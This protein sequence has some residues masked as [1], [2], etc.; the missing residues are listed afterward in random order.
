MLKKVTSLFMILIML[1]SIP[2]MAFASNLEATPGIKPASLEQIQNDT[3]QEI[4]IPIIIEGEEPQ[5]ASLGTAINFYLSRQSPSSQT[6]TIY[7][8]WTGTDLISGFRVKSV[9]VHKG[10]LLNDETYATIAPSGEDLFVYT[11]FNSAVAGTATFQQVLIPT[12]VNKVKL[13]TTGLYAYDNGRSEWMSCTS[14][15][16]TWNIE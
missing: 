10:S 11:F 8:T 12:N 5:G 13:T 3:E 14:P 6:V 2:T 7:W 15:I 16:G 4:E 1:C 9:K